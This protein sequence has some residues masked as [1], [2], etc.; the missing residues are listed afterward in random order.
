[1][2]ASPNFGTPAIEKSQAELAHSPAQ[3]LL[4]EAASSSGSE[5]PPLRAEAALLGAAAAGA[6]SVGKVEHEVEEPATVP[7]DEAV[8]QDLQAGGGIP[9]SGTHGAG[10]GETLTTTPLGNEVRFLPFRTGPKVL[11]HAQVAKEGFLTTRCS[12]SA[13]TV[14]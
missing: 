10:T 7:V 11:F 14:L 3:R 4:A 2:A 6:T 8:A 1:M 9:S 5:T 13:H 12:S